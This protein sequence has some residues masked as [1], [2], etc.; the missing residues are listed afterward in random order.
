VRGRAGTNHLR[1]TGRI[2]GRRLAPGT[3]RIDASTRHGAAARPIVIVVGSDPVEKLVCSRREAPAVFEKLAAAFEVAA[4]APPSTRR[5]ATPGGVL[6][7]IGK[8]IRELPKALPRPPIG[9]LSASTRLPTWLLG[10]GVALVAFAGLALIGNVIRYLRRR[11][12]Y[13]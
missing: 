11:Y 3:Y 9:D 7:A 6:P 8:K 12:A 5:N 4:P 1:F 2:G 13:Y 10:L